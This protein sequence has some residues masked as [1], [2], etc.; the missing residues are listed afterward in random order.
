MAAL[1]DR[2]KAEET[3]WAPHFQYLLDDYLNKVLVET[4]QRFFEKE[5]MD[6]PGYADLVARRRELLTHR[7]DIGEDR[8]QEQEGLERSEELQQRVRVAEEQL[9]RA[10]AVLKAIRCLSMKRSSDW[11]GKDVT[12]RPLS[13]GVVCWVA[14]VGATWRRRQ[15]SLRERRGRTS[16]PSREQKE[17]WERRFSKTGRIGGLRPETL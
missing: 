17:A 10:S 7:N 1:K 9:A 11:P 16:G 12:W 5:P 2:M 3:Q 4:V 15:H 14:V 6:A 8:L 13:D